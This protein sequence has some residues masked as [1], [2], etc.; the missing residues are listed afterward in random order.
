MAFPVPKTT[1]ADKTKIFAR[2]AN[3]PS[4]FY[5]KFVEGASLYLQKRIQNPLASA[6]SLRFTLPGSYDTII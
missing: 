6:S 4:T 5:K 2:V 1:A 3:L